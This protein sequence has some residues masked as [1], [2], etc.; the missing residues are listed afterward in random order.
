MSYLGLAAAGEPVLLDISRMLEREA[1]SLTA[2]QRL[3][4]GAALAQLGDFTGADAIYESLGEQLV[5]EGGVKYVE[6]G[7]SLD[8]R[9]RN[10]AAAL[11]LT[12]VASHPDADPLMRFLNGADTDRAR[13]EV[14]PNLEQ[15]A[16]I[17]HF[18]LPAGESAAKFSVTLDGERRE[19]SLAG[20][21]CKSF[22]LGARA[23]AEADFSGSRDLY[24]C[25]AYTAR[26]ADAGAATGRLR[27]E[28]T[29]TPVGADALA[30]AG[31]ARVDIRVT[32]APDAPDGCYTVTD[33]IPAGMR[34]LP[35]QGRQ[36]S[37]DWTWGSVENEAQTVNGYIYRDRESWEREQRE[38]AAGEADPG[39]FDEEPE[40]D[41]GSRGKVI[42]S[43][44]G[45]AAGEDPDVCTLTYYVS[46]PL[47]G[48][49]VS[50]SVYV[51]PHTE[52]LAARSARG[53]IEIR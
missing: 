34:Y 26:T 18:K 7:G 22:S 20:R 13:S 53:T 14:L 24:A 50:E 42:P 40:A 52:G 23:L 38:L 37:G 43:S 29:Y 31:V 10:T 9:I 6:A 11:L 45:A 21:G 1:A 15:L 46:M 41:D 8:D 44:D 27:V 30:R 47:S 16:Y 49:F 32:F 36:Y 5:S 51:T 2:S 12:S 3:Y 39:Y 28:K 48:N 19:I 35:A 25:A 17:E 4:L 33:L